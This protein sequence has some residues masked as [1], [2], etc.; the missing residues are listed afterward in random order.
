MPRQVRIEYEGAIYHVMARGN[1]QEKIVL[2]DDDRKRFEKTLE[3]VIQK[4]GWVLFA[5]ALMENHYHL[6]FKTPEANLVS[7]MTWFQS[8]VTKRFNARHKVRGHLFSGRYKAVLV[9]ENEYLTTLIH[10]VHLN[11]VRA[12][13]VKVCD[14]LESYPWSSL[15]DYLISSS[16]RRAWVAAEKGL[17]HMKYA[18]KASGR[19]AFLENLENLVSKSPLKR[20]GVVKVEE[21]NLNTTLQRGW[22][23][24]TQE[25]REKMANLIK[26]ER[27]YKSENGY[28][29]DQLRS[30]GEEAASKII[31]EGLEYL[32]I[33]RADLIMMP[34][35]D[36]RKAILARI[37]RRYTR[38][39]LEWLANELCMGSRSSV[40]RAEKILSTKLKDDKTLCK[41]W[42]KLDLQQISS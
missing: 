8:T 41:Q 7:G 29:G 18:D 33:E 24:G 16:L 2:D 12:G 34:K 39:R 23:F 5:Y 22:C 42:E 6:V 3:E 30:H 32:E 17:I 21:A 9:E 27:D 26:S 36:E 25:F 10:Y 28:D 11:P 14:G 19:H 4:T 40:T 38:V 37:V 15:R 31:K 13:L 20:A 35:M 1:H